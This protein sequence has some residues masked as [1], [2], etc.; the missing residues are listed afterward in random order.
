VQKS[1]RLQH[2]VNQQAKPEI[3][4]QAQI[5]VVGFVLCKEREM[6]CQGKI[7]AITENDG[8][9]ITQ[10]F[11]WSWHDFDPAAVIKSQRFRSR[12]PR[13]ED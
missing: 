11:G 8:E 4:E 5:D 7:E 2:P 12:P 10:P 6:G 9:Q 1:R 13:F 3:N